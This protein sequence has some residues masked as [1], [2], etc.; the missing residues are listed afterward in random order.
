MNDLTKNILLWVVIVFVL[1]LVF[2]RYMPAVGQPQEIPYSQFLDDVKAERVE[3]VVMQS[4]MIFGTNKDH[5]TF[6]TRNPETDYT[7][8]IGSLLQ[9]TR[10]DRGARAEAAELHRAVADEHGARHCC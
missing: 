4:E 7:A 6:K 2:S 10:E 5:S 9:G 3:S 1:L 8:L